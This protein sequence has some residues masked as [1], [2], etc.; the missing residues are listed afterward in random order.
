M[1]NE[2]IQAIKQTPKKGSVLVETTVPEVLASV[3]ALAIVKLVFGWNNRSPVNREVHAGL[4]G[5]QRVR[6]PQLTHLAVSIKY[7]V[8]E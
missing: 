1:G 4:C 3:S 7:F 5:M 8:V 6:F 2:E